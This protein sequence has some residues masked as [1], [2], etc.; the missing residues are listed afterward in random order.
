MANLLSPPLSPHLSLSLPLYESA[1]FCM[2]SDWPAVELVWGKW[3][4]RHHRTMSPLRSSSGSGSSL[5]G[6]MVATFTSLFSLHT[7]AVENFC[8]HSVFLF[9]SSCLSPPPYSH[10]PHKEKNLTFLMIFWNWFIRVSF[11]EFRIADLCGTETLHFMSFSV[12]YF[13]H[14]FPLSFTFFSFQGTGNIFLIFVS[15]REKEQKKAF[16]VQDSTDVVQVSTKK[17]WTFDR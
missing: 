15:S 12:I 16:L 13:I 8:S 9:N 4:P 5:P 6:H 14:I 17:S 11:S 3:I 1:G 2:F 7:I 10:Q